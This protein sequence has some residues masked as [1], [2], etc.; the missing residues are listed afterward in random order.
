MDVDRTLSLEE[1]AA[2]LGVSINRLYKLMAASKIPYTKD[3]KQVRFREE[4]LRGQ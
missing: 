2:F 3:G 1:A 4:D